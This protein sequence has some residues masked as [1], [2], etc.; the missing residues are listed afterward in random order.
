MQKF[1][2]ASLAVAAIGTTAF[3]QAQRLVLFEGFSQASCGPCASANPSFHAL[4][5]SG[6]NPDKIVSIKYQVWWPG[7]DPMYEQNEA[8]VDARVAY[9][10]VSGVPDMYMDGGV[11]PGNGISPADVTQAMIDNRYAVTSPIE[12]HLSHDWSPNADSVVIELKIKNV[13]AS[14]FGTSTH[15]LHVLLLEKEINFATAPGSN[16]E[17][18]F[19]GVMR[20]MINTPAGATFTA[21]PA[22]DSLELTYT[23]PVPNYYY[24]INQLSV[25]AFV[26]NNTGKLVE[27][28]ALSLPVA[29]PS[30]LSLLDVSGVSS[31]VAPAGYCD[32]IFT[33]QIEVSNANANPLHS[34]KAYYSI[35]GGAPVLKE[36][37]GVNVLNGS[38]VT[39]AFPPAALPS[40]TA[41]VSYWFNSFNYL[42]TP[43]VDPDF[44]D[45]IIPDETFATLSITSVGTDIQESFENNVTGDAAPANA[46]LINPDAARVYVMNG[47]DA[48][49]PMTDLGGFGLSNTCYRWDY[50]AID[51]N[52][53]ATLVFDNIDLTSSVNSQLTF[54]HAYCQ[55]Q[56]ENDRLEVMV[57]TDCGATWTTVFNKA[58][59]ALATAPADATAR[60]YPTANEWEGD[61]IN[62]SA[63]DGA[64]KVIV[65]F[66]GTSMYGNSL[67]VDDINV[68]S[69]S[70]TAA[71][72]VDVNAVASTAGPTSAYCDY[73]FTPEI[74]ITNESATVLESFKAYYAVLGGSTV[75]Q[76]VT[77]ISI[78]NGQTHTVTFPQATLPGGVTTVSYWFNN[79]NYNSTPSSDL[80]PADN[81]IDDDVFVTLSNSAVG[82]DIVQGFETYPTGTEAP[83]GAMLINPDMSP[84]A[85]INGAQ[86]SPAMTTL[87][88]FGNS[89]TCYRWSFGN[90]TSG[91][92]A[93]LLFDKIDLSATVDAELIFSYAY[94]QATSE[95]DRL[96]VQAS[97]DCG[98]TW[99][100]L[101][102][103]SGSNL[104]TASAT[105]SEF[106]PQS[107]EWAKD[108]LDMSA[109]DGEDEVIVR[110]RGTSDAGNSLFVD[111][112]NL[113]PKLVIYSG[114]QPIASSTNTANMNL[115]PN[116]TRNQLNI[117]F[118]VNENTDL[119]LVVFNALG[120]QVMNVA[121]G[122][123][124]GENLI[125]INAADLAAGLYHVT[126]VSKEGVMTQRFIV[127]K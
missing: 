3:G 64:P 78:A 21:I 47:A 122:T 118:N 96:E 104:S 50:W 67:Y 48:A 91:S 113:A 36:V 5:T 127:E 19:Y 83:L 55:Y 77:G 123:F 33:P 70:S 51:P 25:A 14:S 49:T 54:A 100:T 71:T 17:K 11:A 112:I 121:N 43:S 40:G 72:Q 34:F 62:L 86:A 32:N 27:N 53:V 46:I 20:K 109:F 95:N 108:T 97:S 84:V 66:K 119:N 69:T 87:G 38:S 111:D 88:G 41:T 65:Q 94:A 58:G 45:N 89:N 106:Y 1:L 24:N 120:Q 125:S 126:L 30:N 4:A 80:D 52:I 103:M 31:T 18:N 92:V 56:T 116:P 13:S 15:R 85:I 93:T 9:Y 29:L 57:S 39:V 115:Y 35:N 102:D 22:G 107:N 74:T 59:S 23:V 37:M 68:S 82:T 76:N 98:T 99:T 73:N 79:L 26:Q 124:S 16:G 117:Q 8:D 110:F 63:Y 75:S 10:N 42:N 7:Y 81:N 101:F 28:A 61:T 2:L 90:I 105:A 60:F 44:S 114:I 6:T 12:M